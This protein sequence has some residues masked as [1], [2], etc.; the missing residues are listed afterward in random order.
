VKTAIPADGNLEI[1]NGPF[2]IDNFLK[3]SL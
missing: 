3:S 2:F 1:F